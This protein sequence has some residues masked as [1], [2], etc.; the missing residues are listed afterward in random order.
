MHVRLQQKGRISIGAPQRDEH[1]PSAEIVFVSAHDSELRMLAEAHLALGP[2]APSLTLTNCLTLSSQVDIDAFVTETLG[3]AKLVVLRLVGGEAYW[4]DGVEALREWARISADRRLAIVPGGAAWDEDFARR[5]TLDLDR[6]RALWRY[7]VEGGGRNSFYAVQYLTLLIDRGVSP[8]PPEPMPVAGFL[9]EADARQSDVLIVIYRAL[10]QAGDIEPVDAMRSA[11]MERGVST[12]AVFVSS[13]KDM[14]ARRIIASALNVVRPSVIINATAFAADTSGLFG[15]RLVLQVAFAGQSRRDWAASAR[16]MGPG[17]LAMHVVMPELDGRIFTAPVAFKTK[18]AW[19]A[20]ANHTPTVL[21]SD[22]AQIAALADRAQALL[23]L[24]RAKTA[25]RRIAIVLANYPTRDGRLA[26]GVGLD[27]PQSCVAL[28]DALAEQG[29]ATGNAPQTAPLLVLLLTAGSTNAPEK[30]NADAIRWSLSDYHEAFANLPLALQAQTRERWGEPEDDPHA[31]AGAMVLALHRFGNILIGIQPSRGYDIDPASSFHDPALVPPHRYIATYLWMRH[32]FGA[33]A[34]VHLGKH[35][36]LEW[37]PGKSVGLSQSC[38]PAALIGPMPNIYP[39]IVNDPGEGVQAKRRTA[40]VIIDHLTPPLTRGEL[41]GE[42]ARLEALVDEYALAVD[43]DPRRTRKLADEIAGFA[44]ILRLD[45]DVD[46]GNSIAVDERVRR[47]DAHLCDLKEMQIRDGLHIFGL[48]PVDRL[49]TDLAVSIAR[50]PRTGNTNEALSLHRAIAQDL[51]FAG[52]DPLTRDLVDNWTWAKPQIL[53]DMDD[54]PWRTA[55]DT[56]ERIELLAQALVGGT[57][58][59]PDGWRQT[60]SVLAWISDMLLPSIDQCGKAETSAVLAALSGLHVLPGPSGAPSRGRPDVLPTGRNFYAV[61]PRA[62]PTPAAWEIGKASAEAL[63]QRHWDDTGEW[64]RFVAFS[65]WGTAN[66]RTG[67]DDVAQA[68]ALI[69]CRPLWEPSSGRVTGFEI[70]T[71]TELKRPRVDVTFRVSGLFRDAFPTQI[72][73]IDSAVRAV[74]A[75]DE[76]ALQNPIAAAVKRE[77]CSL[78]AQGQTKEDAQRIAGSRVFG[79]MPGAYGAGLQSLIDSSD[80]QT[81]DDL[82]QGYLAWGGF[83]YGSGQDGRDERM[84]FERRLTDAQAVLHAQDN[85][86]HDILDSDDYYQFMGGLT[87]SIEMLSGR[88][89]PVYHT[90]TS[91]PEDPKV[92]SLGEEIS[93]VVRGRAANPK[94]IAGVMRHGYKGAF[95]MAATVDYLFAFAASTDGVKDHHFEQLFDAYIA[96]ETVRDF[97]ATSNPA[98]LCEMAERLEEAIRRNLWLPRSNSAGRL[99]AT[100]KDRTS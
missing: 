22:P 89:V 20:N 41:H 56:V 6:T 86:E 31:K 39:F 71:S 25:D 62:V 94:W 76:D 60:K 40:A 1:Q 97:I 68:L 23:R 66:M 69:G 95:E 90:D 17:D 80:W 18:I 26:N 100:I 91:R 93:R 45:E 72:E 96:D 28:L 35:G 74:A 52:F 36:N 48:S 70:L 87:A 73:L 57:L 14:T 49:R 43:L 77:K 88:K 92:R 79:S 67:G 21:Q 47:V 24:Q 65:A 37:L 9:A 54:A 42:L 8:P 98:A 29:Y 33:H 82:A 84:A 99:L 38:W 61:D 11:F 58:L 85:R 13:L 50:V 7:L 78:W 63:V 3:Q 83:A 32:V 75:L 55:G 64:L 5:G 12:S 53:Q 34:V 46:L 2:N 16:G 44:G 59:C 27:T 51:Q 19:D 10:A 30:S 4:P 81:R 15:Q